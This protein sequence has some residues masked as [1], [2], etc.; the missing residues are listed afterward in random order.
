V[1]A[2][3]GRRAADQIRVI[4]LGPDAAAD[5]ARPHADDRALLGFVIQGEGWH[6]QG[7]DAWR[8]EPGS[9]FFIS[10]GEPHD[11]SGL[12]NVR[13]WIIEFSPALVGLRPEVGPPLRP[14]VVAGPWLSFLRPTS[15]RQR[16][17]VPPGDWTVWASRFERLA[18]ELRDRR[19]GYAEA[20]AAHLTVML[21]DLARLGMPE[22]SGSALRLEPVAARVLELIEQRYQE[23]L[24]VSELA[25]ELS[26]SADHL[27]RLVRR[28]TGTP[29]SQWLTERRMAE[30]RHRLL[31]GDEPISVVAA[32]VGYRDAGYFRR[33]FRR[34]HGM[35]PRAWRAQTREPA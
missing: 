4:E 10:P 14:T 2:L 15:L 30:A 29:I 34:L 27:S 3:E 19:E 28:A 17:D 6:W 1:A 24:S 8:A 31:T 7:R 21:V 22:L 5:H 13:G 33:V 32:N 16:I 26:V 35:S 23:P 20:A 9:L 12:D 11:A 18:A 25:A